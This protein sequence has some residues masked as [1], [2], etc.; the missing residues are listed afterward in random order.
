MA[1]APLATVSKKRSPILQVVGLGVS[2]LLLFVCLLLSITFGAADIDLSTVW[3]ALTAFDG[4]TNHL[5]ITTLRLPRALI[6]LLVGAALAVAG[7][8]MQGLTRNSL[9]EPRIL[10]ISAGAALAVVAA[11]FLIGTTSIQIYTWFAF[12]GAAIAAVAVYSL[13]SV[14]RGG[15]SPLKLVLAGAVLDYL[16]SALMTGILIL[17]RRTLDEVRFWLAGSVAGRD[18]NILLQVLP[19]V[20][21]GLIIA[22]SLG[23]QITTLTLGEDVARG[24][25]LN[26][27]WVKAIAIITVV[28]LAGSAVALAGPIGF[29]GLVIPHIVRFW[30]GVDYRWILPYA[31]V[32]GAVLLLIA[33]LAARLIIKPQELPV[34]IMMALLGAPFFIYLAR[35]QAKR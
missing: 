26:T 32:W 16:L 30:V 10:G 23:K 6:A 22:F 12:A 19:Y 1:S 2:I 3:Q 33:D 35:S 15:L 13:G 29:V 17:D 31:A 9:A 14:G 11:T 25:G 24:L 18:F 20:L 28:L 27:A 4:S 21:I 7:A 5:I 34:G 8:L